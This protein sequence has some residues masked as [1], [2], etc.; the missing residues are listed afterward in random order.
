MPQELRIEGL[1]EFALSSDGGSRVRP[2]GDERCDADEG[3]VGPAPEETVVEQNGTVQMIARD[4]PA[5]ELVPVENR[6]TA[7]GGL[8]EDEVRRDGMG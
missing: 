8:H 2:L 3:A 6:K 7:G 1:D 5:L 4:A